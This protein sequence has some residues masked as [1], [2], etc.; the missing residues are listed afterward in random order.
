MKVTILKHFGA[1]K[2]QIVIID[3]IDIIKIKI[4]RI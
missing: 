4:T 2:A 3:P 1:E